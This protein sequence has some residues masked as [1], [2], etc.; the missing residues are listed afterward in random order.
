MRIG[1]IAPPWLPIPPPLYGGIELV[2]DRLATGLALQGHEVLLYTTGDSTCPVPRQ[3]V[4][5]HAEGQRIGAAVPELRH[6]IA[7]YE[8]LSG[9]DVVHDHSMI[10]PVLAPERYP[11]L[12]VLTTIHGPFNEELAAVY[13]DVTRSVPL[14]CISDAQRRSAGDVP[15]RAVIHHGL[16]ASDFPFGDGS[17]GHLLFLGRMAPEKGAHTA[18]EV[19]RRSGLPLLMAAKMREPWEMRYFEEQVA[20]HLGPRA[21]YLGEVPHERKLELLAGARALL[22]PIR[23]NEPFGMVMLEAMACGTPVVAFPE[24]AVPEV[25]DNGVNGLLCD[26][27][28]EMVDAV[29]KLD[30]ID[31]HAC[32]AAVEGHF[33]TRRM[34]A[35]HVALY[36][37]LLS[38][39]GAPAR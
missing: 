18:I 12:P 5:A 26:D 24:G 29:A 35:D 13:R 6:V 28:T 20:P 31:R 21:T 32:R 19:A 4:L 34:V 25:V 37:Q 30:T 38:E 10:G 23:W 33:S 7:A 11:D 39:A 14:V 27:E 17:G 36:E 1:L 9:F 2:V 3:F 22:F 16:D 15:V 8:A